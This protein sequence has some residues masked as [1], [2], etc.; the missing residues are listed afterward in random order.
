MRNK[1]PMIWMKW[2]GSPNTNTKNTKNS[3]TEFSLWRPYGRHKLKFER[4]CAIALKRHSFRAKSRTKRS[5]LSAHK[6]NK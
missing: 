2:M 1:T 3:Q 4:R 5:A 6:A